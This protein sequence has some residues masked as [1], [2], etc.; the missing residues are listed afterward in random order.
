MS[1]TYQGEAG[2]QA[3]LTEMLG[4]YSIAE[5]VYSVRNLKTAS[6]FLLDHNFPNMIE[7]T[8]PEVAID[9]DVGKRRMAP[10]CS[11]LVEGKP[12]ASRKFTTNLFK[13]PYIKDLRNPDLLKPVRRQI[14][15]RIGGALTPMQRL[16]ANL[17]WEIEDQIDM[18]DRRCEW[19]AAQALSTGKI[20][21]TGDGYPDPIEIDFNRDPALTVA[22]SGAAQWGQAGIYPSD[23]ILQW[24]QT[25]LQKSGSF[26]T[27]ITFTTSAW[28]AFKND[29]KV[30]NSIIWPGK[31]GGSTI[32]LG[33]RIEQGGVYMGRWG[34]FDL[35]LYN[36][37]FVDPDTDE[38]NPMLIDGTIL[39]GGAGVEGTRAFG[40]IMDPDFAYGPLAYAPKIW[41]EKNPALINML[42]Q[43]APIM[44]P[45]RVNA[46]F[47]AT[48]M[49]PGAG[50]PGPTGV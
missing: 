50:V 24:A 49:A 3:S 15:E 45:S 31:V 22:L 6:T 1:D 26:P 40:M 18:I 29:V 28:N 35:Y 37:W 34:Q 17:Q 14:G 27:E 42:M 2:V 19:M 47:A 33:G 5:L 38:E 44:I 23:Y 48:V 7:S 32:E 43:S 13:P 12:V 21:V 16:E 20:T 30:L 46:S 36:D 9:V 25:V 41:T 4:V 10:F 39:M 11:P 8:A